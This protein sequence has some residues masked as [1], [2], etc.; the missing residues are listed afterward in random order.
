MKRI[1]YIDFENVSTMGLRGVDA[2]TKH[3][4]VKIFLGP[5]CSKMSLIDADVIFH[6]DATVELI[7]NDQIGKNA[8]DFIIMVHMGYDIAKKAGDAFF[9][10]S[11]DKG[12]DPAIHEMLSMT[13]GTIERLPSIR[14]VLERK[15]EK[16]GLW[17]G[18]FGKKTAN[19]DNTT[20]H[21]VIGKNA[22]NKNK[23][24]GGG[25]RNSRGNEDDKNGGKKNGN[26][27][28]NARGRNNQERGD[29]DNK[30]QERGGRDRGGYGQNGRGAERDKNRSGDNANAR[31]E[32]N[33][34]QNKN[35]EKRRNQEKRKNEVMLNTSPEQESALQEKNHNDTSKHT[36]NRKEADTQKSAQNTSATVVRK[37]V[38]ADKKVSAP[39]EKVLQTK[40]EVKAES[41]TVEKKP[42]PKVEAK[43]AESIP[44]NAVEKP[45]EV[46]IKTE[47]AS[48][49][50]AELRAEVPNKVV[51][52][53]PVRKV[54]EPKTG[55]VAEAKNIPTVEA[56]SVKDEGYEVKVEE[57]AKVP[58]TKIV[59]PEIKIVIHD[60]KKDAPEVKVVPLAEK[61]TVPPVE[62]AVEKV[63]MPVAEAMQ[64]KEET[65]QAPT[66]LST[67][68]PDSK[69]YMQELLR[70]TLEEPEEEAPRIPKK[71]DSTTV[72]H[73]KQPK[74][75]K[76][77]STPKNVEKTPEEEAIIRQ[78]LE[79]CIG[80]EE[81][82]N[83]LSQRLR[84]NDRVAL[85]YKSE[86]KNVFDVTAEEKQVINVAMERC[87]TEA[88]LYGYL[89]SEIKNSERAA[90]IYQR[91]R[92]HLPKNK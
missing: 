15:E 23:N 16:T 6:S 39:V 47:K 42:E 4:H 65:P 46:S 26:R 19:V 37:V 70:R 18:L 58:E 80:K 84:D 67:L 35:Q 49:T 27:N 77:V 32:R 57:P 34:S 66:D 82:H 78:A 85:L 31:N 75:K 33:N 30:K 53:E 73:S 72:E 45:V 14:A 10:I 38:V 21:E 61:K 12:Y 5:K 90:A 1:L 3:D 22:K 28:D 24:N 52:I 9:I 56:K 25:K 54:T 91:E 48:R 44:E 8:L 87:S 86:K 59:R 20:Q 83:Y 60:E 41:K 88:G 40:A 36:R 63:P 68:D 7:K 11:N 74:V 71:K 29:R 81:F 55:P 79:D 76:A 64:T 2:L 62:K 43:M 50:K 13:G 69:Q 51:E 92:K 17:A 89:M